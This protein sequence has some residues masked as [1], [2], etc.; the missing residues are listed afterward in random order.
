MLLAAGS[1]KYQGAL[2]KGE[3]YPGDLE[4]TTVP[5]QCSPLPGTEQKPLT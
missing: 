3:A 4:H 1:Q 2:G 5:V